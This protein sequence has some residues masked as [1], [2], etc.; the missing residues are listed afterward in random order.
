MRFSFWRNWLIGVSV[1]HIIFGL[2]LAFFA[3]SPLMD[4]L[5]NQYFD[6]L[7]WPEHQIPAG[8]LQYKA[9]LS[10]VLGAVMVSWAIL[11]AF[12]VYYLFQRRER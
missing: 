3:E 5:L 8:T 10:S 11:I 7:F 4:Q 2:L 9:W 12:I 6:P 1:Y